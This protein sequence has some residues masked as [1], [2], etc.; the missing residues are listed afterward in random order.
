MPYGTPVCAPYRKSNRPR[1]RGIK[2]GDLNPDKPNE[3]TITLAD[4]IPYS[5]EAYV[6][7]APDGE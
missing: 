7:F 2:M 6:S 1:G 3:D 5:Y 4:S